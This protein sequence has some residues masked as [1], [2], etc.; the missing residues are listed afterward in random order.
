MVMN[1]DKIMLLLYI[2]FLASFSI[3]E[4]DFLLVD[5][6][7]KVYNYESI[8]LFVDRSTDK[9]LQTFMKSGVKKIQIIDEEEKLYSSNIFEVKKNALFI[10]L[11]YRNTS[12]VL[13]SIF[14]TNKIPV[15]ECSL[16]IK[17]ANKTDIINKFGK[18][19]RFDSDFNILV[20]NE[21]NLTEIHEVYSVS[22]GND[23]KIKSN[24]YGYFHNGQ[25]HIK[26]I[27]LWDR[28]TDFLG[29]NFRLV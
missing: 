8:T 3:G 15:P 5:E 7:T 16:F 27:Y 26:N 11:S 28:R 17:T 25:L 14:E 19:L 12:T 9:G 20:V 23:V 13:R 24:L 4:N 29:T 1:I 18:Y 10:L 21:S 2:N 6:L 22:N